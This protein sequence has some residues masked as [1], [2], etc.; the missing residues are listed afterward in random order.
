VCPAAGATDTIYVAGLWLA[1]DVVLVERWT[2]GTAEIGFSGATRSS[3]ERVLALATI[4]S[5]SREVVYSATWTPAEAVIAMAFNAAGREL[6][7][8]EWPSGNLRS[9]AAGRPT[10]DLLATPAAV[11]FLA[12]TRSMRAV[13]HADAGFAVFFFEHPTWAYRTVARRLGVL[14]DAAGDGVLDVDAPLDLTLEQLDEPFPPGKWVET[15][16]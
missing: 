13:Q 16:R 15:Y 14:R 3:G 5:V 10:P 4:P 1:E 12:K 2:F 7:M 9:L 8:L 6:L 11:P